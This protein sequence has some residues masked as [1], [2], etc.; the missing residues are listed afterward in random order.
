MA[1]IIAGLITIIR[2]CDVGPQV[3]LDFADIAANLFRAAPHMI[4]LPLGKFNVGATHQDDTVRNPATHG[5]NPWLIG[6]N[7]NRYFSCCSHQVIRFSIRI[8]KFSAT[9]QG[10]DVVD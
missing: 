2:N 3:K 9:A 8:C 7:E 10:I 4:H 1:D 5:Q 6:G